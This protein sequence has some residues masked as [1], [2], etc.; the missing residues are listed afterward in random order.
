MPQTPDQA[1][2]E[3]ARNSILNQEARVGRI[4]TLGEKALHAVVKQYIEMDPAKHEKKLGNFVVDIFTGDRIYEI[5]TQQFNKLTAKLSALLPEYPITIVYP[6]PARKWLLWID[7]DSG[8]ITKPRLSP[9]RGNVH[10]VFSELYRIKQFLQHQN[11]SL[12][13]IQIDLEEYRLLNGWSGDRKRGSWRN[14]RLPL[15]LDRELLVSDPPDFSLLIP[16]SL[17]S[18]FTSADFAQAARIS[19][20]IAQIG[21]NILSSLELVTVCGKLGR[22]RLYQ[23]KGWKIP[24]L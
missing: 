16:D 12:L 15:A 20:I 24:V 6:M 5:Q 7:P 8:E 22:L 11:L 18:V 9:K 14:D 3:A 4:G 1:R 13:I 19:R 10:T 2:F 23:R 21:L 17:P